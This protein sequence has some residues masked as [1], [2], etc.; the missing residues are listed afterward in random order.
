MNEFITGAALAT[1]ILEKTE[2]LPNV[3]NPA[4]KEIG[5]AIGNIFKTVFMPFALMSEKADI[6]KQ[7]QIQEF[8][9]EI[10]TELEQIPENQLTQPRVSIVGS[11]LENSK[12]CLEE[13]ELR[14]LFAKQIASAANSKKQ[15]YVRQSF[16]EII[17]QLE[18]IDIKNL[19]YFS[20][21][22]ALHTPINNMMFP[23][24]FFP[25]VNYI[26]SAKHTRI[27]VYPNFFLSGEP[28]EQYELQSSSISNLLRLGLITCDYSGYLAD[29]SLYKAYKENPD[30]LDIRSLYTDDSE[31]MLEIQKG[32][33]KITPLGWD[34]MKACL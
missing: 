33:L 15:S 34:F 16:A 22:C 6:Y 18:P 32:V 24:V 13:N 29:D 5:L 17:K 7:T 11:A 10:N 2:F 23:P 4:S 9:R 19:K 25:C 12:Y 31:T 14:E 3:V 30:Y 8:A 1:M 26:I 21:S 20:K 28:D 27:V